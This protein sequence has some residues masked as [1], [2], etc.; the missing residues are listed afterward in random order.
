MHKFISFPQMYYTSKVR[1]YFWSQI[2]GTPIY[3]VLQ[4]QSLNQMIDLFL[5][6]YF[7]KVTQS[8]PKVAL[9]F[10]VSK[11]KKLFL[12]PDCVTFLGKH[13]LYSLF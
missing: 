6:I 8:G 12:G 7:W 10:D 9:T 2:G 13:C 5:E 11:V 3:F 1:I 4:K